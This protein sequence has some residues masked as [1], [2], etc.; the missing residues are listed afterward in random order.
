MGG[1][2]GFRIPKPGYRSRRPLMLHHQCMQLWSLTSDQSHDQSFFDLSPSGK[3]RRGMWAG[4]NGSAAPRSPTR[5]VITE[6]V[7]AA[8]AAVEAEMKTSASIS[9]KAGLSVTGRWDLC[10][11]RVRRSRV[12]AANGRSSTRGASRR[13]VCR[14]ASSPRRRARAFPRRSAVLAL[15]LFRP[16]NPGIPTGQARD[17]GRGGACRASGAGSKP[18]GACSFL[19]GGW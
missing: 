10:V 13:P 12:R 3:G 11:C 4:A 6:R 19:A 8:T 18:V 9:V 5:N 7:L 16:P 1:P 15:T 17:E 14:P 2:C